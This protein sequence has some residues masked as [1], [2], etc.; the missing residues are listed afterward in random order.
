MGI[1][2]KNID[3]VADR[4]NDKIALGLIEAI[5]FLENEPVSIGKISKISGLEREK[6]VELIERLMAL[7]A[8]SGHGIELVEMAGGYIFLP[9]R[10]LWETLKKYYGKRSSERLSR[11]ALETLAII[12][13]SQPITKAEIES[14]RGVSAE[15]MIKLLMQK[16]LIKV[17]GKKDAPGKPKQY[18]TTKE[19]LKMFHLKSISD[20]PKL[21]EA[22]RARFGIK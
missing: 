2:E 1:A 5:I 17:V 20:L 21:K 18:G 14:I 7:Y 9:K 22:D 11:A 13:Y 6:I 19:F 8:N 10:N 3:N 16:N 12:A 4:I 15:S